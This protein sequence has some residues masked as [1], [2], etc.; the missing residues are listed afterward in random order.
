[1]DVISAAYKLANLDPALT[2]YIECHGTGTQIGDPIE[3]NA[4]QLAM[5]SKTNIRDPILIGSVSVLFQICCASKTPQLTAIQVKPN[6][7]HS[8]AASS[9][10]TIIKAVLAIENGIIPPTTGLVVPNKKSMVI[11]PIRKLR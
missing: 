10:S 2:S 6:I 7:G 4:I 3:V 9:M 8:E 5:R 1:M 11:S